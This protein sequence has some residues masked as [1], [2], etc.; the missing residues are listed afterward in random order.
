MRSPDFTAQQFVA[1]YDF[2]AHDATPFDH[3]GHG[4]QVAGT[5]AESTN[6]HIGLTGLAYGAKLMPVR[7]LDSQGDGGARRRSP[8]ASTSPSTTM[9]RSST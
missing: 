8:A 9:R 2:I 3:N 7:V 5:I 4:T 1:G 6:N